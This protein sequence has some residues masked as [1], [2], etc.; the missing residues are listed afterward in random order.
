MCGSVGVCVGVCDVYLGVF[1]PRCLS[2]CTA[3]V[4][5]IAYMELGR[6]CWKVS[7]VGAWLKAFTGR[8]KRKREKKRERERQRGSERERA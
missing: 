4:F 5:R 6:A 2:V 8:Q 3:N 7:G 1:R